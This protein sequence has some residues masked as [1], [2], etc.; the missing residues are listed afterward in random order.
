MARRAAKLIT[1]TIIIGV[2]LSALAFTGMD[3]A[4]FNNDRVIAGVRAAGVSLGD[5]D[6]AEALQA[7]Q[8]AEESMLCRGIELVYGEDKWQAVPGELGLSIDAG[9]MVDQALQAGRTGSL[10]H[11]WRER[12]HVAA[13]G[14]DLP[15]VLGLDRGKLEQQ[16]SGLTADLTAAPRDARFHVNEDDTITIIPAQ[17]GITVDYDSLE[18]DLLALAGAAGRNATVDLQM[19]IVPPNRNTSDVEKMGIRGLL[20]VFGTKFDPAN[21]SRSYN[22]KVAAA[23]L[24]GVLVPPGQEFSFNE[25]VGPRSSEAGYKNAPII[26][27]NEFVEGLGGGVCQVSTTLYNAVLLA[28]LEIAARTNHSLPVSYVPRGRDATV[29]YQAVDFRFRNSYEEYIYIKSTVQGGT[30][31]IKI[32]GNPDKG[33]KVE[34]SSWDTEVLEPKVIYEEDPNLI[35]GEQ[36]VKQEGARGYKVAA[37]RTIWEGGAPVKEPL[38]RSYYHPINKIVAVG[39]R[40]VT[41]PVIFPPA[42]SETPAGEPEA[43]VEATGPEDGVVFYPWESHEDQ[44]KEPAPEAGAE[45]SDLENNNQH[46]EQA[47]NQDH[48]QEHSGTEESSLDN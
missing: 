17:D 22:V 48:N 14:L 19:R 8:Q 27:N 39:T 34:L 46:I 26:I 31:E 11:K 45:S 9:A 33:K 40:E 21:R 37:E 2:L 43:E 36:V 18:A 44:L 12:Q 4:P 20:A 6:R 35:K 42:A 16:V 47:N 1:G 7:V 32:Y 3:Y 41:S 29:V 24:D 38:P 15:V 10:L 30:L 13:N 23:A 28:N 25:V 5:L